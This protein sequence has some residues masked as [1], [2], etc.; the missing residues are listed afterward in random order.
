MR[1]TKTGPKFT[2]TNHYYG[3]IV[4]L[5]FLLVFEQWSPIAKRK[6]HQALATHPL[7]TIRT[8]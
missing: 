2:V 6:L 5:V 1:W 4:W 7:L 8:I 3:K